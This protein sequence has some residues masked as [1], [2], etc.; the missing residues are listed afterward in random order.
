MY[1]YGIDLG[2]TYSCM[3]R[4]DQDGNIEIIKNIEGKNIT[5]SVVEF[6]SPTEIVVG[7]TAKGDAIL[8]PDN[9]VLYIKRS[10]GKQDE[11]RE[12]HGKTFT[13][14]QISAF[15]LKKLISDAEQVTG[16][17][18]SDVVIT[19]PAYFGFDERQATEN[20]GKIAGLN[21]LGIVNEPTA[22]AIA[23]GAQQKSKED[24]VVLVYDLGGGTFDVTV[25]EIVGDKVT[26]VST[27]GNHTLGGKDWDAELMSY[28][29]AQFCEKTG[30][31]ADEI[32]EDGDVLNE[33]ILKTE[34]AKKELTS[35]NSSSFT[36]S[37]GRG[38]RAK[39]EVT[40]EKFDEITRHHLMSTL[41]LT[42]IALK[43]AATKT[44]SKGK[45]CDQFDEII[46]VGGSTRM[47]QVKEAMKKEL[48]VDPQVFEPDEAVARGAALLAHF[49]S[50]DQTQQTTGLGEGHS[51][52][53]E[54]F[55][56]VTSKS[57]GVEAQISNSMMLSHVILKNDA[58]P[59]SNTETYGT[60]DHNQRRVNIVVYESNIMEENTELSFGKRIADG[61]LDLPA[62]LPAR[63][64]IDVTFS[65]D[66][67]GMLNITAVERFNGSKCNIIVKT[68]GL[69]ESEV[70]TLQA[71]TSVIKVSDGA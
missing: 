29:V 42:K 60:L 8:A 20:A 15:I 38:K 9:V 53:D 24:K 12:H 28:F 30:V 33:L 5:P 66:R 48:G 3:A 27:E 10:M 34:D 45:S 49:L 57:Y 13:P 69:S 25:A 58:I 41:E 35:K 7:E 71:Q 39:L 63:S 17:K 23:Y 14:E 37:M 50:T 43:Q 46:F 40:V 68:E 54:R 52:A 62:G 18:V 70:M 36:L 19:V 4:A 26:V 64:P 11:N 32:Y 22:A 47:R 61:Q 51:A 21:V 16:E 59:C 56:E 65:L 31:T 2:T 6:I 55:S 1:A 44:S 67:N